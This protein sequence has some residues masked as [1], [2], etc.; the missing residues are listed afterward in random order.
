MKFIYLYE[1]FT[2]KTLKSNINIYNQYYNDYKDDDRSKIVAWGANGSQERNFKMVSDNIK[3]GDS[4]LD[5]GCGIGD[6]IKYLND[7]NINVSNYLGVD[8]NKKF[9]KLAKKTYPDYNFNVIT[10]IDQ[11]KGKWDTV[12]AIGVFTWFITKEE[13][14]DI[15]YKLYN[16]CN[17]Q[18]ILTF[19]YGDTP[20]DFNYEQEDEDKYWSNEYKYYS[21]KLFKTLFNDL[22]ISYEINRTTLLIK[23]VK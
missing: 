4:V 21:P 8:I 9:I 1:E 11:I 3:N 13:F 22:N 19:L 18:L 23:I 10:D 6:F 7:N 5:Y 17:K 20:Y 16:V 12:C 14:I 15:I 2:D